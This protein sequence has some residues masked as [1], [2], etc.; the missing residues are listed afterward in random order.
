M[1]TC[2]SVTVV[3]VT[4]LEVASITVI[5]SL[6]NVVTV[7]IT[8]VL[9]AGAVTVVTCAPAHRLVLEPEAAAALRSAGPS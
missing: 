5:C 7:E 4:V 1:T 3:V 8:V 6:P 9:G 2:V